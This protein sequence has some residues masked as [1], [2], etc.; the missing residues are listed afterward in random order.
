VHSVMCFFWVCPDHTMKTHTSLMRS[1]KIPGEMNDENES[2]PVVLVLTDY[3]D[4]G[5]RAGGAPRSAANLIES[6]GNEYS[7]RVVTRDRDLGV[8]HP[9]DGIVPGRWRQLHQAKVLYLSPAELGITT[10]RRVLNATPYD[11]LYLNSFF[12]P[13]FT[14]APLLLRRLGL[15]PARPTVLAPRGELEP[16][17]LLLKRTKKALYLSVAKRLGLLSDVLWHASTLTEAD[18]FQRAIGPEID[19]A[20]A[21]DLPTRPGQDEE[22]PSRY[23]KSE[24]ALSVAFVSRV[25]REKNLDV[26]LKLVAAVE[27]CVE[28]HIYGPHVDAA[29]WAECESLIR[30]LPPNIHV[31]DHGGVPPKV[32]ASA[33]QRHHVLLLPTRGENYG[34][35]VLEALVAG[36]LPLISDQ[37]RW[38]DLEALG[39]G[40]DIS[41]SC[42]S[43][44]Q[45]ALQR[46]IDMAANPLA[47]MSASAR[48]YGAAF[49]AN[50]EAQ[51]ENRALLETA[52]KY[53]KDSE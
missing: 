37:T 28:F 26:A 24:G 51:V 5:F 30:A 47:L 25:S 32:I 45:S 39:V 8:S 23:P 19:I 17:R 44:F 43:E 31:H 2:R 21:I 35:V 27:G 41:L 38:R 4:P 36:C 18:Y 1:R 53:G 33:L 13:R 46:C 42:P 14:I 40:W 6:L 50:E 49:A 10:L 34:H 29:Y 11:V 16:A 3:F 22:Q 12:S 48:R 9:Y 15:I 20:V 52:L 7:F